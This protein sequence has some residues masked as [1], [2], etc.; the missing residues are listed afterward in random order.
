MAWYQSRKHLLDFVNGHNIES[1]IYIETD[2][3]KWIARFGEDIRK[4]D[5]NEQPKPGI[6]SMKVLVSVEDVV[7][8]ED[9][10]E[11]PVA[12]VAAPVRE[13]LTKIKEV[14]PPVTRRKVSNTEESS[15]D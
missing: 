10:V 2:C 11:E 8:E 5:P 9:V 15:E 14:K 13:A 7:T 4:L 3:V 1:G 6:K 12:E